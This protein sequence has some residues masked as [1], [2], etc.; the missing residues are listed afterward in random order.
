MSTIKIEEK[1]VFVDI[2]KTNALLYNPPYRH[3][4]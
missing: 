2:D 1:K 3:T 4:P